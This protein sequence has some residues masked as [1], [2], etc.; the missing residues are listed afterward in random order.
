MLSGAHQ[1]IESPNLTPF[2]RCAYE[3]GCQPNFP[4]DVSDSVN[5]CV[6]CASGTVV[7]E[8]TRNA[9]L[10]CA[11]RVLFERCFFTLD[12]LDAAPEGPYARPTLQEEGAN[13]TFGVYPIA[14]ILGIHGSRSR[15][16]LWGHRSGHEALYGKGRETIRDFQTNQ[17][18]KGNSELHLGDLS[19]SNEG[20]GDET[21][22]KHLLGGWGR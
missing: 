11:G 14:P 9:V 16:R 4:V 21:E 19:E 2:V 3:W 6:G 12:D 20:K 15:G 8:T 7:C 22:T 10:D 17:I 5:V 18:P 13:C 1:L